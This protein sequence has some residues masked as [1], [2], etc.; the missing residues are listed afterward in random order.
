MIDRAEARVLVAILNDYKE[1]LESIMN[2]DDY[3]II[4]T[5]KKTLQNKLEIIEA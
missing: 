2:K 4:E 3:D 5:M 1:G